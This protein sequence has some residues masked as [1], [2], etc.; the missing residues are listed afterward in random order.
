MRAATLRASAGGIALAACL[1]ACGSGSASSA[2]STTP[3]PTARF[4]IAAMAP[5]PGGGFLWGDRV[6]GE[7]RRVDAA[8]R[9]AG[10]VVARVTVATAHLHGLLGL[11][12]AP[13]G[14]VFAAWTDRADRLTVGRVAPGPTRVIWRAPAFSRFDVGGH[15]A[16]TPRG[17]LLLGVGAGVLPAP[18]GSQTHPTGEL[19]LLRPDQG[20]GQ[21]P[22]VLSTGW[23]NPFAFAYT[24]DGRLW[25]ADNVPGTRGERLARGDLAGRPTHVTPLAPGTAP[26]GLAAVSR[27]RLVLCGFQSHLLQGFR[28][29]AGQRAVAAGAPIAR[30][31]WIG[32]IR[33]SGG[34]LAYAGPGATVTITGPTGTGAG[35]LRLPAGQGRNGSG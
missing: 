22:V 35:T 4:L 26:S 5:L 14:R 29:E 18:G 33:L 16:V 24:P 15:L 21:A 17:R 7:I 23:N 1:T 6:T 28:I 3:P 30:N 31:C 32:V 2:G 12:R 34:R 10:G 20:P 8:G 11:A 25:V 27:S 9:P 19:L 13:G